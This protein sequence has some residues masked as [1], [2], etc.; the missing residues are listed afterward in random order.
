MF[1]PPQ[2]HLYTSMGSDSWW[3]LVVHVALHWLHL[4][5]PTLV[6]RSSSQLT[7][8]GMGGEVGR[9]GIDGGQ[10]GG[11]GARARL[12]RWGPGRWHRREGGAGK[13]AGRQQR[14]SHQCCKRGC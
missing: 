6:S 8:C 9:W 12:G 7:L 10:V 2:A 5:A 13:G 11:Q 4:T 14:S 1:A 3:I